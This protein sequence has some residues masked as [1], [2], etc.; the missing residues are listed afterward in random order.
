MSYPP[1]SQPQHAT[2][3]AAQAGDRREFLKTMGT[4]SVGLAMAAPRC[5]TG[6]VG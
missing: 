3:A 1:I 2:P 4:M 6:A 5:G